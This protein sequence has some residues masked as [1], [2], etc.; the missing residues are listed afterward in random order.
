VISQD[1]FLIFIILSSW[2][3]FTTLNFYITYEWAQEAEV[4]VP[5]KPFQPSPI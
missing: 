2:V 4:F 3:V 5:C 1:Y